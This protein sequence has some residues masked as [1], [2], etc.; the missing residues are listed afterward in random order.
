MSSEHERSPDISHYGN[1]DLL[2]AVERDFADNPEKWAQL[3]HKLSENDPELAAHLNEYA[4]RVGES[5]LDPKFAVLQGVL[6]SF[7]IAEKKQDLS[8]LYRLFSQDNL[9]GGDVH[10]EAQPP[11]NE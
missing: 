9:S 10:D 1:A 11:S 4:T 8:F 5:G 6:I 3:W 7:A 2:N